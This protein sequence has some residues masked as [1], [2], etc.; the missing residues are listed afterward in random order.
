MKGTVLRKEFSQGLNTASRFIAHRAQLPILSNVL[1]KAEKAKLS[2]YATNL[3]MSIALSLGAKV[4]ETGEIAVPARTLTD[5]VNS[6]NGES[7]E[8]ELEQETFK[9][10]TN[11]F[12]GT[13]ASMN[14][15]DFPQ[16][17]ISISKETTN[18]DAE[19][20]LKSISEVIYSVSNDETRPILSGVLFRIEKDGLLLVASDGYRLA[21]KR[22]KLKNES[23]E[24]S[25]IIPKAILSE[26]GR[27]GTVENIIF[28]LRKEDNQVIFSTGNAILSSR[29]VEGD[30]PPFEAVIQKPTSITMSV[31]KQDLYSAIKTASIYARDGGNAVR[32]TVGE[33]NLTIG[34]QSS[35]V[36]TQ[37][38]VIDAKVDGG[39][40]EVSL[41]YKFVEELLNVIH[42]E[43][44]TIQLQD[45]ASPVKFCESNN[46][47]NLHLVM[48]LK[49]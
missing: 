23:S 10:K 31:D 15:S 3:E 17:P 22:M 16:I 30:Y 9:L 18:F 4:D 20:L 46:E 48:P 25:I 38:T 7:I 32:F 44:V 49:G 8:F 12:S 34:A 41:N 43:S 27:V 35:T 39:V 13:V 37:E 5:L 14:T 33:D 47:D 21:Q 1:I 45:S 24:F 29:T 6:L 19:E 11:T 40:T 36:G 42:S 28:E 2:I 26:L